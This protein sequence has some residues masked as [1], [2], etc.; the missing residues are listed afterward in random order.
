M[1]AAKLADLRNKLLPKLPYA[2]CNEKDIF[3]LLV[4]TQAIYEKRQIWTVL[5][6]E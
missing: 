6:K 3:I 4:K 1:E 2:S 5:R